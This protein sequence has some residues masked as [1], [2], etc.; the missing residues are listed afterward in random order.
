MDWFIWVVGVFVILGWTFLPFVW[1]QAKGYT[2]IE[3]FKWG[4]PF[5]DVIAVYCDQD[6]TIYPN[7]WKEFETGLKITTFPNLFGK[8]KFLFEIDSELAQRRGLSLHYLITR[9]SVKIT[10]YNH[11]DYPV[12]LRVGTYMGKLATYRSPFLITI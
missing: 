4:F 6:D 7:Q 1:V 2:L 10:L 5:T 3:R 11:Q 12:R 8:V 9:G